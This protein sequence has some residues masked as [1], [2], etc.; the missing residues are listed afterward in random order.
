LAITG[1]HVLLYTPEAEA[2]RAFFRDV[3]AWKHVDAGDGWLIFATPAAELAVH[4]SEGSTRHE[5]TLMCDDV[6][7]TF[8]ELR[9]KGVEARG[10]PTDMGFGVGA[11]IVL[12]GGVEVL[13]YEPK[14]ASPL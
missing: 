9:E 10:E 12:P 1:A 4:P 6:D 7:T 11:T 2:L 5:L 3:L 8:G 14:H 13:L